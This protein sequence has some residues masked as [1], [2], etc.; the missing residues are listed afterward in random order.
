MHIKIKPKYRKRIGKVLQKYFY[1]KLCFNRVYSGYVGIFLDLIRDVGITSATTKILFPQIHLIFVIPVV[2]VLIGSI[3]F[4]GHFE[5]QN[6]FAHVELQVTNQ[7]NPQLMD[8]H[9]TI[10]KKK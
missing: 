5:I 10:M 2:I 6:K 3:I 9:K 4:L 8:I 1:V 7:V